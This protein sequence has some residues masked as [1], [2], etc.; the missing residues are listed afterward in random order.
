MV[1]ADRRLHPRVN[2]DLE[3][4]IGISGDNTGARIVD[5]SLGGVSIK[6]NHELATILKLDLDQPHGCDYMVSFDLPG[7]HL[8]IL[9]RLVHVRRLSQHDYV[10]GIKF[11]NLS[12]EDIESLSDYIN[13]R[14][15]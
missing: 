11:L 13:S 15:R 2:V 4:K 9:S 8:S 14:A 10:F 1:L 3:V 12:A 6:G 7:K 5:I